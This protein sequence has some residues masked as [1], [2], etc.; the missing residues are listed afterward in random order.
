MRLDFRAPV[1]CSDDEFGEL[2]DVVIDPRTKQVTRLVVRQRH[3]SRPSRLAPIA[4]AKPK[5]DEGLSLQCK[6]EEAMKL[7]C[8]EEVAFVQSGEPPLNDPDWDVGIERPIPSPEYANMDIGWAG[9]ELGWYGGLHET[10][11]ISYDRVPKGEVEIGRQSTVNAADREAVGHVDG[12]VID[13]ENRLTHLVL[14][15]GHLWRRRDITIPVGAISKVETD[16]VTVNLTVSEVEE[17]P[18]VSA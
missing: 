2:A 14:S 11:G 12:L 1:S 7:D 9:G 8:V 15:R 10:T 16:S 4:L 3:H 17:L 18:A 6:V 5:R 13:S